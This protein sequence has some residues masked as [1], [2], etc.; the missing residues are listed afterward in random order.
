MWSIVRRISIT[1]VS[2]KT[3]RNIK[4]LIVDENVLFDSNWLM[5]RM[6]KT[7]TRIL[8]RSREA[9]QLGKLLSLQGGLQSD[10]QANNDISDVESREHSLRY[11]DYLS[12]AL[13]H[14]SNLWQAGINAHDWH[15]EW[16]DFLPKRRPAQYLRAATMDLWQEVRI[17][18]AFAASNQRRMRKYLKWFLSW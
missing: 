16:L 9:Q 13:N 5:V 7:W 2:R 4:L 11:E 1:S 12:R 17:T 3:G 6:E 14:N 10:R 15:G 8:N 18:A